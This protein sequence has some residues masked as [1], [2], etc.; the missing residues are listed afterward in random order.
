MKLQS[1]YGIPFDYIDR[2]DHSIQFSLLKGSEYEVDELELNMIVKNSLP[3]H[4]PLKMEEINDTTRLYY[5]F[6]GKRMLAQELKLSV[7]TQRQYGELCLTI[8]SA[9]E[10]AKQWMLNE[11]HFILNER[12]IFVE[13][14]FQHV[15]LVYLPLKRVAKNN[16]RQELADL[17]V[18]LLE[19]VNELQGNG[20]QKLLR[21]IRHETSGLLEIKQSLMEMMDVSPPV[22]HVEQV[23][24]HHSMEQTYTQVHVHNESASSLETTDSSELTHHKQSM[25]IDPH[26]KMKLN[27]EENMNSFS[28]NDAEEEVTEDATPPIDRATDQLRFHF[29]YLGVIHIIYGL[30]W[31]RINLAFSTPLI[32][33]ALLFGYALVVCGSV[34]WIIWQRKKLKE[35]ADT[36]HDEEDWDAFPY[37]S[38]GND[39]VHTIQSNEREYYQ[40]YSNQTTVL[41]PHHDFH[42]AGFN[43]S[44]EPF[45]DEAMN[46]RPNG[47]SFDTLHSE[48][49][50]DRARM[51]GKNEFMN[52]D[53]SSDGPQPNEKYLN[54][55]LELQNSAS[56]AGDQQVSFHIPDGGALIGRD[57]VQA[58]IQLPIDGLSR[59]HAEL[60]TDE[61]K[62][63]ILDLGSSNGTFINGQRTVPYK[64]YRLQDGD[65]IQFVKETYVFRNTI[66]A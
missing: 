20:I 26:K 15:S 12:F 57:H 31:W 17:F 13:P 3:Y 48:L 21:T 11:N 1:L 36:I 23:R 38:D 61:E 34:G 41:G 50:L 59:L 16:W 63:Y 65:L 44:N 8:L 53:D 62:C 19:H 58:Q 28:M 60:I 39:V 56:K 9:I 33:Y 7:L 55:W 47:N 22:S 4:L 5:P 35:L 14:N 52:R 49:S 42:E 27:R 30:L 24:S 32:K 10:N 2:Y 29:V 46:Q 43:R 40:N 18:L 51:H 25:E 64:K 6:S 37:F 45:N 66:D 54:A